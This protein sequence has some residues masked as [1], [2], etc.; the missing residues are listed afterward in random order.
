M[1]F[2]TENG[3]KLVG[4]W[5]NDLKDGPG[6]LSCGNG[7]ILASN[8]LF[9]NDK[10]V[11]KNAVDFSVSTT[12][13]KDEEVFTKMVGKNLVRTIVNRINQ[14]VRLFLVNFTKTIKKYTQL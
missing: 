10:P 8:P 2:G 14:K 9:Q 3:A 7:E 12:P 13:E 11:H 6:V 1:N 4:M 5:V